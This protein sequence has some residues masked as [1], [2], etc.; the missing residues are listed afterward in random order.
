MSEPPPRS[1]MQHANL[2]SSGRLPKGGLER[3]GGTVLSALNERASKPRI[4]TGSRLRL[5]DFLVE[6]RPIFRVGD[7]LTVVGGAAAWL[8]RSRMAS[9]MTGSAMTSDEKGLYH[10]GLP[11]NNTGRPSFNHCRREALDLR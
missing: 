11:T 6:D 8:R 2:A 4:N 3:L 7:P 9:A 1:R 5:Q 10:N